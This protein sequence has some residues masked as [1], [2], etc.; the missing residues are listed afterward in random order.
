[1]QRRLCFITLGVV[2]FTS[3]V[4]SFDT[5][6]KRLDEKVIQNED[7][8][9]HWWTTSS[10]STM[11]E[12]V[13]VLKDGEAR[14]ISELNAGGIHDIVIRHDSIIISTSGT[15]LFYQLD[16]SVFGYRIDLDTIPFKQGTDGRW[17]YVRTP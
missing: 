8:E 9:V 12:H 16:D 13:E 14:K 5:E 11:H 3:C 10:I 7:I 6:L 2:L 4:P 15:G 17:R 1:M